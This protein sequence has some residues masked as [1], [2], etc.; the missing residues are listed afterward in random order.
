V[1]CLKIKNRIQKVLAFAVVIVGLFSSVTFAAEYPEPSREFYVNDYANV[2]DQATEDYINSYS[3]ALE[4]ATDAQIVV[5]AL[6]DLEEEILEEYSLGLLREWG[7][8]DAKKNNGV[9][10]LLDVG[11]RQSRIEIGYGL[12]GALP[13]GK[14][15][16]IQDQ[17]MV[18]H[19]KEGDYNTG[20]LEGY[21]AILNEVSKEYGYDSPVGEEYEVQEE[22]K[23]NP[24][25][26]IIIGIVVLF[27]IILDFRLTGGMFT[28]LILRSIGRGGGGGGG[29]RSGGGGSGGGGGSSR[30]W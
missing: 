2:L 21:K 3:N 30:G 10:I 19:F 13:D 6:P 7:I 12:E 11:G 17:F 14:T 27:L 29:G 15:G 20:I 24:I 18:P 16:R 22:A 25:L 1:I 9:L 4:N 8:G 26:N 23:S 5:V 28:F